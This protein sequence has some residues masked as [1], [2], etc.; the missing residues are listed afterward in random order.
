MTSKKSHFSL[1]EKDESEPKIS[2]EEIQDSTKNIY[3]GRED[4]DKLKDYKPETPKE[5][6]LTA[7]KWH[8]EQISYHL[9]CLENEGIIK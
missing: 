8:S 1:E 2:Y 9:K 3:L 4:L 7:I 5:R 6:H